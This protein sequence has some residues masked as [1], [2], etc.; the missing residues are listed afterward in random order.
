[1]NAV[2]YVVRTKLRSLV[3]PSLVLTAVVGIVLGIVITLAA[4]A[5]RTE[6]LPQRVDA[7]AGGA[8]DYI[9]TQQQNGQRPLTDQVAAL[10]GVESADSYS[11][12]FGG[13]APAGTKG[14]ITDGVDALLFAGSEHAFGVHILRG[15][16]L[17]QSVD[18]EFVATES[19]VR[20]T[21]AKLGDRFDLYT[22]SQQSAA[23]N[24]FSVDDAKLT[25][26]ATLVGIVGG[27]T[28]VDDP[29]VY[30]IFPQRLI[31]RPDVGIAL[32][33]IPVRVTDGIDEA[34]LRS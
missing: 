32:T 23:E 2:T 17:D 21:G 9:I 15:R 3:V 11:F 6:T 27:A 33:M 13:V 1:M 22:L 28:T 7:A 4:G 24:G 25:L 16:A 31:D 34:T 12:V 8:F 29:A 30:A 14:G 20:A 5:H 18:D 10:P 26:T 19:F